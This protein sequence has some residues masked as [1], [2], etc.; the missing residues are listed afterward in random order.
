MSS[1]EYFEQNVHFG[2]WFPLIK[3][4]NEYLKELKCLHFISLVKTTLCI[5]NCT[6]NHTK[7]HTNYHTIE[8]LD[9]KKM[10][11]I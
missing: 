7:I 3:L 8:K 6:R 9:E 5:E 11:F 2:F 10:V 4:R 1:C